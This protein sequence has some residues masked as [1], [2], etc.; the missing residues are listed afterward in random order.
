MNYLV[1]SVFMMLV[2]F[3]PRILPG[4]LLDKFHLGKKATKF[5]NLIPYTAM[6]AL[7]FPSVVLIDENNWWVGVVGALFAVALSLFKKIPSFVVVISSVLSLMLI[8]ALM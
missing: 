2:T 5:L 7:I 6:S 8:Y 4:F 3:I 1:L